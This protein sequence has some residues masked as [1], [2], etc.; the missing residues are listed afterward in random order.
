MEEEPRE[1]ETCKRQIF[2]KI[3]RCRDFEL[4]KIILRILQ[5]AG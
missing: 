1:L 3:R 2:D 5:K 4:L